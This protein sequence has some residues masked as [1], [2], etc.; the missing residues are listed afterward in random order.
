MSRRRGNST[1]KVTA[2]NEQELM[3]P[4]PDE[5]VQK[6]LL[7]IGEQRL[8]TTAVTVMEIERSATPA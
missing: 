7:S 5:R 8:T 6:W 2:R 3:K 4:A 1:A